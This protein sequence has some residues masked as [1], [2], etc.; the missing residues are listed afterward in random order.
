MFQAPF[1]T[2]STFDKTTEIAFFATILLAVVMLSVYLFAKKFRQDSIDSLKKTFVGIAFGFAIGVGSLLLFLKLDNYFAQDY[3]DLT[4][5]IPIVCLLGSIIILG[6]VGIVLSILKKDSLPLFIKISLGIIGLALLAITI[7]HMVILYKNNDQIDVVKEIVLYLATA[8]LIAANV[9]LAVFFGKKHADNNHTKTI[10][11]AGIFM[12]ASFALSY[13][14]L[15]SLPQGG[16]IT[17]ASLL[18]LMIFSY[19]F[20]IR[21]GLLVGAI[22]GL[23]QFIQS[24]WF[25]HPAQFLLDYP[26]AFGAIGLAGLFKELKL[27]ADKKILQFVFG[28]IL[29]STL[30]YLAHVVSG[31]FVFGS[32]D[33]NYSAVAWS[34]LYNAFT[35]ADIAVCIVAGSGLFL[36][37]SFTNY[38]DKATKQN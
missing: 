35:F 23:L 31:I 33:P 22:Y 12:A 36:S 24:P 25:Y 28:A 26:V 4:T 30:R 8:I 14:K 37:K 32:D 29:A 13:I 18:P 9:L 7:A 3:V 27:F 21:K 19:M 17:F 6:V 5:F 2:L 11:Y 1:N 20:G 15:F 34:F 16:S 38:L 10:V